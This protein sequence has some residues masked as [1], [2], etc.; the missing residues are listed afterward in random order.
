MTEKQNA[1]EIIR[2]GNPEKIVWHIPEYNL[3]YL[4]CNH[5]S[6]NGMD[7][8]SPA[9]SQWLDIWGTGWHKIHEG[10]MGLPKIYP[11][12][13]PDKLKNYQWPNPRDSRIIQQVYD[14]RS[15]FKEGLDVY[16]TGRHRDTLWEKAYM[17]VGM[18]DLFA[19]LYTEPEFVRIVFR[20]I[21]D[22]QLGIAETYLKCG[23]EVVRL[24]DDLGSQNGP[25]FSKDMIREFLVPEY[26]R[27]IDFYKQHGIIVEFHSCGCVENIVDIFMELGVDV[28]NPIQ[29]S[30]NN[31]EKIRK[32][33]DGKMCLRGGISTALIANGTQE[34]IR[35]DVK[36]KIKLLGKYG[37][38]FCSPDQ[39]IPWSEENYTCFMEALE[40][41]GKYPLNLD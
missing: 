17:L 13:T 4:G 24:G 3:T 2:F 12:D 21:M 38:Y 39:K 1:L 9:G 20:K 19:Y 23:A 37:G 14:L 18:E 8:T 28:L 34:E 15:R 35:A 22:F 6:F 31:L 5:E 29:A 7:D 33:T 10:V 32:M 36:E 30:A 27:L 40:E 11:L 16:I 25:L 26:K 41:F